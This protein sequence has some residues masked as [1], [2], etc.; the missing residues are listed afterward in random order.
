[1]TRIGNKTWL[2][3][4]FAL[5]MLSVVTNVLVVSS[6]NERLRGVDGEIAKLETSIAAQTSAI[7]RADMKYDLFRMMHHISKLSTGETNQAAGLDALVY[8]QDYL[9]GYY[10]AVNDISETELLRSEQA[11]IAAMVP[12]IEKYREAE[13]FQKEGNAAEAERL[14]E[15]ASAMFAAYTPADELGRNVDKLTAFLK[16][17][18]LA[19]QTTFDVISE[20]VPHFREL[21]ARYLSNYDANTAR[22]AE[23]REKRINLSQWS[24][25]ATYA[26]ISL[27]L[28]ALFFF[29]A[30][31][32]VKEKKAAE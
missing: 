9:K 30:K 24:N 7:D 22:L 16:D 20:M 32:L 28:F 8:L 21:V 27:Q 5:S 12:M 3:L 4:G 2:A 13:R 31:D 14:A 29:F 11:K 25:R 23:L 15:E 18:E 6:I 19:Q 17:P 1:M 10:A 26:A